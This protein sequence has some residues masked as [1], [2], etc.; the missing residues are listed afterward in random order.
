[1]NAHASFIP[2]TSV[3]SDSPK[4]TPEK[5]QQLKIDAEKLSANKPASDENAKFYTKDELLE[6]IRKSF[7]INESFGGRL[8][9]YWNALGKAMPDF[10]VSKTNQPQSVKSSLSQLAL[11]HTALH[12]MNSVQSNPETGAAN[13]SSR[14]GS[15]KVVNGEIQ[16][17]PAVD[18]KRSN[19][20][21]VV[22]KPLT[23]EDA[24]N[25]LMLASANKEMLPPNKLLVEGGSDHD[26]M[27]YKRAIAAY[28]AS[29]PPE[30]R[31][32]TNLK[33]SFLTPVNAASKEFEK[34]M[35][36]A[37]T[38]AK[39]ASDA[40]VEDPLPTDIDLS[41][42]GGD[43]DITA[44]G[45]ELDAN[46]TPKQD[47]DTKEAAVE[48]DA[49]AAPADKPQEQAKEPAVENDTA[50]APADKPQEQAKEPAVENDTTAAP[51]DKQQE[52]AKEPAV[53]EEKPL[54][55]LQEWRVDN[56][57]QD[58]APAPKEAARYTNEQIAAHMNGKLEIIE[59]LLEQ[60]AKE[61][62]KQTPVDKTGGSPAR[63]V[64]L[65]QI[66]GFPNDRTYVAK[67][68]GKATL[69]YTKDDVTELRND[70][71]YLQNDMGHPKHPLH[72]SAQIAKEFP[73]QTSVADLATF[74][75]AA[76]YTLP[77][78]KGWDEFKS[79]FHSATAIER[80]TKAAVHAA[81][82]LDSQKPAPKPG[83]GTM[84]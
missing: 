32:D 51:A 70:D 50:D 68:G 59:A 45:K 84:G 76:E 41:D 54:I 67:V 15:I 62:L 36:R 7:E 52:Q 71:I 35:H 24:F 83:A 82:K 77:E 39:P 10:Y 75:I 13:F 21:R 34:Y 65:L 23:Y 72:S 30:L 33:P 8:D 19:A 6:A 61:I 38:L 64:Y 18:E 28:N 80:R 29:V 11:I 27:I 42:F 46:G 78:Y 26:R 25:A 2:E 22:N 53:A 12:S 74:K 69:V 81:D 44:S 5:A 49:T 58:P 73:G 17:I 4:L 43:L 16:F 79:A 1:M 20:K 14:N 56:N 47:N 3:E 55:L 57:T 60:H 63:N 9:S 48:N 31:F 66:E 37:T 40:V